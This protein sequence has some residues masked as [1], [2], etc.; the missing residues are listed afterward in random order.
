M[1]EFWLLNKIEF[2]IDCVSC[3]LNVYRVLNT[4]VYFWTFTFFYLFKTTYWTKIIYHNSKHHNTQTW[5]RSLLTIGTS[6]E[7]PSNNSKRPG[8]AEITSFREEAFDDFD[9]MSS[10]WI[11]F[12]E[13][14]QGLSRDLLHIIKESWRGS[15]RNQYE[16]VIKK[17]TSFCGE[18]SIH[19]FQPTVNVLE[20]LLNLY[21]ENLKY[22]Y[23]N[24]AR[25]ALSCFV[26]INGTDVGK[27]IS[28]KI[29]EW[30]FSIKAY[31]ILIQWDLGM[32]FWIT[33]EVWTTMKCYL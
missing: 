19:F 4:V 2:I 28:L 21:K 3:V 22:S 18:S 6:G 27:P 25:S 26:K 7:C 24:T 9:G 29:H 32:L 20:I 16:T 31:Y 13:Q 23:I 30:Y 8:L 17:W 33:L 5:Y 15:T 1:I 12:H 14:E 10:V 11:K